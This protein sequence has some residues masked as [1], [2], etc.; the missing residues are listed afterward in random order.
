MCSAIDR[1]PTFLAN[2]HATDWRARTAGDRNTRECLTAN[3]DG[4]GDTDAG[5]D[6]KIYPIE[7]DCDG[8]HKLDS[9]VLLNARAGKYGAIAILLSRPQI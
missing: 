9:V 1:D 6:L 5:F 8:V 4:G 3:G 7:F 2:A